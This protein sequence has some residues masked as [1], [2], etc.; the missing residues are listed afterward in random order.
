VTRRRWI[1]I[2]CL[3]LAMRCVIA[4]TIDNLRRNPTDESNWPYW[5]FGPVAFVLL[6][7]GVAM[8]V[9]SSRRETTIA[10]PKVSVDRYVLLFRW[11]A[12]K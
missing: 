6:A 7:A 2:G 12:S 10:D 8:A 1:S 4:V 11:R 9:R 5:A 3:A